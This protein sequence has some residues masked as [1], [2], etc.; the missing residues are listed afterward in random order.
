ML[1]RN[2]CSWSIV[3]GCSPPW[4]AVLGGDVGVR[5]ISAPDRESAAT[6]SAAH[7]YWWDDEVS[8][9][10][11]RAYA[12][13]HTDLRAGVFFGVGANETHEGRQREAANC[14]EDLRQKV[15][16]RYIDMVDDTRR[17]VARLEQRHYP[18]P[19]LSSP[20][21]PDEFHVSVPQ[22][23]LSRALRVLFDAPR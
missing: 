17:M 11:E 9:D 19:Q 21:F 5:R 22:L 7:H 10:L 16:P 3:E 4:V 2:G 12:E 14:P 18:N 13:T 23:T 6:R 15:A 8:F 20:V 1:R